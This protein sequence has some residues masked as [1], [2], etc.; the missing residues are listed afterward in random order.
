MQQLINQPTHI[1][2]EPTSSTSLI[3]VSQA[4]LVMESEVHFA[5]H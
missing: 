4:I 2:S 3:L 1:P 5:L